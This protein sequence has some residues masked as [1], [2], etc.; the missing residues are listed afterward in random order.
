MLKSGMASMDTSDVSELRT[1]RSYLLAKAAEPHT[2]VVALIVGTLINVYGQLLVPMFRGEGDPFAVFFAE[3]DR[4]PGTFFLSVIVAYCFPFCVTLYAAVHTRYRYRHWESR[5]LFPDL[6]PDPVFRADRS[7]EIIEAGEATRTLFDKIG[8]A[9]AQEAIGKSL[10]DEVLRC[11]DAQEDLPKGR[12]VKIDKQDYWV[13]CSPCE[14]AVNI[15]LA[16]AAQ[17][18]RALA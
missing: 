5:A 6:K 16:K 10:F 17:E 15:Y 18:S 14:S 13:T 2:Y 3:I 12:S 7:G 1:R 9:S 8:I 11:S 4:N